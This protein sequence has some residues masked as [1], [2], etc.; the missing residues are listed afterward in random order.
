MGLIFLSCC[1]EETVTQLVGLR[2]PSRMETN[3]IDGTMK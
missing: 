2:R 1:L 3:K